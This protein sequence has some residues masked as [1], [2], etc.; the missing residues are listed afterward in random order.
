MQLAT[1][2]A[3]PHG[4]LVRSAVGVVRHAHHQRMRLPLADALARLLQA[5]LLGVG[6][7]GGQRIGPAQKSRA[8]GDPGALEA[9]IESKKGLEL[10][11]NGGGGDGR[12]AGAA[13]AWPA[14]GESIHA[15][16]P[17]SARARS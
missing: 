6:T 12:G 9:E 8:H 2:L 11:R 17:S 4:V 10:R 15:C 14:S 1:K 16:R 13:H 5:G 3:R 7:D